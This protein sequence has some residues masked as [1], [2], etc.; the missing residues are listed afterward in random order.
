PWRF[1]IPSI[2]EKRKNSNRET[3]GHNILCPCKLWT[4]GELNPLLFHAMEAC[5]RY[6]TGPGWC[7]LLWTWADSNRLPLQC[8]C[9]VLPGELQARKKVK[10]QNSKLFF[11]FDFFIITLSQK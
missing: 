9:N 4:R 10:T 7:S 1:I 2:N 3:Q 11:T 5:Y 6:T 8:E